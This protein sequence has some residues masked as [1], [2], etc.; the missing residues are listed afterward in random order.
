MWL[1]LWLLIKRDY[2]FQCVHDDLTI[3]SHYKHNLV[4]NLLEYEVH[5]KADAGYPND[6]GP[7]IE[8]ICCGFFSTLFK[9]SSS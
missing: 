7:T 3:D 1:L 9:I 4:C 2:T 6:W 5:R 8:A